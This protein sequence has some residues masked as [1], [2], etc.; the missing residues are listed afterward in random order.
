M[1]SFILTFGLILLPLGG[2]AQG[3]SIALGGIQQDTSQPVEVSADNLSVDQENG[4]AIFSGNVV[5]GQ[6][7]MRLAAD[8]VL[9][10]YAADQ[11]RIQRLEAS[12]GVTLVTGPDAAEA[13][14]A[15]YDID[16]GTV[17]MSG[18]VLLTQGNNA[19][20]SDSM[21]VDLK[22][23]SAQMQGRVKTVLQSRN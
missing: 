1:P 9:V 7:E 13:E 14:R 23:G 10:V 5:I 19:L 2:F 3:T 17:V 20:T 12:G 21:T 11:S 4:T 22:T 18:D 15:D 8:R 6:G 16:A